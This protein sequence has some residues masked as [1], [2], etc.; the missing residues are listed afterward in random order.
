MSDA[1]YL[2]L[3]PT[4]T[5]DD[6]DATPVH[7]QYGDVKMDLPRLDDS[8]HLPTA[9][10]IVSMQVVSTGWDNLDY[11]DKIRVMA[12]ILAW[13]T[14]KYPRLERELDTKSTDKLVDLGRIIGAWA[15]ATKGLDPKA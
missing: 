15:D 10:I 1:T 11:E 4:D 14:S 6:H 12:T 9:V 13:L 8:T 2:D 7:I 3:T 5:V